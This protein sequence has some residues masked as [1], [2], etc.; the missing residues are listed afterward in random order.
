KLG[1]V[2]RSRLLCRSP[3]PCGPV[4]EADVSSQLPAAGQACLRRPRRL[5]PL[6][7]PTHPSFEARITA[8]LPLAQPPGRPLIGRSLADG[9]FGAPPL[10]DHVRPARTGRA[11][12]SIRLCRTIAALA[13]ADGDPR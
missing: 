1:L 8:V 12:R 3:A 9:P 4:L 6:G 10:E 5:L 2:V 7:W 13:L 11:R